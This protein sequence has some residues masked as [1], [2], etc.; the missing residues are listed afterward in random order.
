MDNT[1]LAFR[2]VGDGN[3]LRMWKVAVEVEA[4]PVDSLN[5]VVRER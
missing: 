4:P 2:K 3:L 5:R 1:E